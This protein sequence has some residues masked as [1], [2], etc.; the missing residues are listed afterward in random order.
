MIEISRIEKSIKNEKFLFKYFGKEELEFFKMKNF[1]VQSIAGNFCAK[2]AFLKS[3][4]LRI[5]NFEFK[6]V[7]ILRGKF[8]EPYFKFPEKLFDFFKDNNYDFSISITH[9]KKYASA[10]VVYASVLELVDRH[11]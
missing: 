10:V 5:K 11:V 3:I 7:Q 6:D 1:S 4:K 8:K 9:T 2:E